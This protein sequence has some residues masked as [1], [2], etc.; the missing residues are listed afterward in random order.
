MEQKKGFH[1]SVIQFIVSFIITGL[2]INLVLFSY[3]KRPP[4][5]NVQAATDKIWGKESVIIDR[6]EGFGTVRT[7]ANGY[8]NTFIPSEVD[9][10]IL[11]MGSSHTQAINVNQNENYAYLLMKKLQ[12]A[13]INK[14]VY[15]VGFDANNFNIVIEHFAAA[16]QQFPDAEAVIFEVSDLSF[17]P[18]MLLDALSRQISYDPKVG[19]GKLPIHI[20]ILNFIQ[21]MPLPRLIYSRFEY[22]QPNIKKAFIAKTPQPAAPVEV[23]SVVYQD[24]INKVME[25]F[26]QEAGDKPVLLLYNST[27][28]LNS[29]GGPV[30]KP[31]QIQVKALAK[32]CADNN[33]FF[34]DMTDSYVRMLKE[35]KVAPFGFANAEAGLG[36]LNKYGHK[37]IADD[38]FKIMTEEKW[39]NK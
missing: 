1:K 36:H 4:K 9:N 8:N 20:D 6:T 39:G 28:A 25:T 3:F 38:L 18:Q 13:G 27:V 24:A 34:H 5:I 30:A 7:D 11:L 33:I 21:A 16:M 32:A 35:D 2:I 17:T 37:A 23:D 15:N 22:F 14:Y 29:S 26:R 31:W 10:Y 19:Q 12:D